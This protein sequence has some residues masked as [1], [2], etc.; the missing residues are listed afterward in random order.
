MDD[1]KSLGKKLLSGTFTIV[2]VGMIAKVASFVTD[3]I[4][5]AYLGTSIQSDSYY[6][7]WGIHAVIYP[8]LS[9]G[10]W[11]VF[12]PLY[13]RQCTSGGI[14]DAYS[15]ANKTLTFF[16]LISLIIVVVLIIFAPT[17]VSIVAPGFRDET[18][19]L[20]IKLVRISSPQYVFII[21][22]AVY[23]AI[24]QSHGKFF[25]SQVREI[26][27]YVPTIV[28]A[29]FFYHKY[30]TEA[31]AVSLVIAAVARLLIEL[32]FIDWGYHYKLDFSYKTEEF[33]LMLK[34][35]PSA[36][37]SSGATQIN[38]LVDKSMASKLP[39]GAVSGLNYGHKLVNVLSGFVSSAISTALYPQMVE[40]IAQEKKEE[41]SNIVTKIIN[42]FAIIMFPVTI[43]CILF[44]SEI[45]TIVFQRGAF[46]SK[47]TIITASVFAAYSVGVFFIACSTIINNIFYGYGNTK[48]PMYIS[49]VNLLVNVMLN[50]I[51]VNVWGVSGLALATSLSAIITF[52]VR[53]KCTQKYLRYDFR[54]ILVTVIK[55]FL[56]SMIAC[57]IP[58]VLFWIY[59]MNI[60]LVLII[61]LIIG[62]G[63]YFFAMR[64]LKMSEVDDLI[65][66]IKERR[67]KY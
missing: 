65:L 53:I 3:A 26:V 7:I 51:M 11:Q 15:L 35:L 29:L 2:W 41:L 32:P 18:R 39:V 8:M 52:F 12:L 44:R 64:L 38:A 45:V 50:I 13:K 48:T 33:C 16:S 31:L 6:M 22:S 37:I 17:V 5:A 66:L 43:A 10:I 54:S 9:V 25:G 58:R 34:R 56:S 59:P 21:A 20:T 4:L 42:I 60:V 36:L 19:E 14:D 55:A 40:L 63:V 49:V 46:D 67:N 28:A 27:S 30:G 57:M 1:R 24:L 61:S 62:I 47:S 23:A